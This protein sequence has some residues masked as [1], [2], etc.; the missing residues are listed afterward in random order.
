MRIKVFLLE[1]VVL[2]AQKTWGCTLV[3][4]GVD[5]GARARS[6][7]RW[8]EGRWHELRAMEEGVLLT[9]IHPHTTFRGPS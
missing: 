3:G 6:L 5:P 4:A 8:D 1:A 2:S 9:L 7:Q